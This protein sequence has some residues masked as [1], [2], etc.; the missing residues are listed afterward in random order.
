MQLEPN[1][2]PIQNADG[3]DQLIRISNAVQSHAAV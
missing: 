1:D 2:G 3:W